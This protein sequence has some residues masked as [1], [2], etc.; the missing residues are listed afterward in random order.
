MVVLAVREGKRLRLLRSL[1]KKML[2]AFF[3]S[4]AAPNPYAVALSSNPISLPN[5]NPPSVG[6]LFGGEGGIRTLAPDNSDLTI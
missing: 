4:F 2:R 1:E 3:S 6:L 5:K